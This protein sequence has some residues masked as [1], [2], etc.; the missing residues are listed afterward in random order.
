LVVIFSI[1]KKALPILCRCSFHSDS[2]SSR[3]FSYEILAFSW[4]AYRLPNAS[5]W[6]ASAKR[7]FAW[8]NF[9][10]EKIRAD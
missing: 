5:Q 7:A 6:I 8:R 2:L 9:A 10:L 3:G 4:D 1:P